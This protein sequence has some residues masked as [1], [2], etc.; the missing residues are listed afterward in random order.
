LKTTKIVP[1]LNNPLAGGRALRAFFVVAK[2]NRTKHRSFALCAPPG[3]GAA[4][5]ALTYVSENQASS[6]VESA[7]KRQTISPD[8]SKLAEGSQKESGRLA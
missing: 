6:Q 7:G 2:A 5:F 8:F 3:R 1:L 4:Y